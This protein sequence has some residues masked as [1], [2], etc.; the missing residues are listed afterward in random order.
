[1]S[2]NAQVP[3][4]GF[5]TP[6]GKGATDLL[7]PVLQLLYAQHIRAAVLDLRKPSAVAEFLMSLIHARQSP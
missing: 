2:T 4:V 5:M 6:Q 1:M 3:V 7:H